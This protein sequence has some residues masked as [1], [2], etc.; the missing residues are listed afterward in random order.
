MELSEI[1]GLGK[2]R[3]ESL[4]NN[5]INS[6]MDL[7]DYH[8]YKYYDFTSIDTF[9]ASATNT[10]LVRATAIS[11]AKAVF[12]KGL[13][14]VICEFI[15]HSTDKSFKAVWYNQPFMK[16]NLHEGEE[17]FLFGKPNNKKQLVIQNYF[18]AS[19]ED[20]HIL[21]CYKAIDGVASA[22]IKKSIAQILDD[23]F[24]NDILSDGVVKNYDIMSLAEAYKEL[25]FPS[26]LDRLEEAKFRISLDKL[27]LFVALE[28]VIKTSRD[29]KD[30]SYKTIT[31]SDFQQLLPYRLTDGQEEAIEAVYQDMDRPIVMNRLV[32]GDV[33]SGKTMVAFASIYKAII[34][35]FQA[36]ML[37][38]TE[39]L[40]SQ[41][42][43]SAKT[44]FHGV[45]IAFLHSSISMT[46]K[47]RIK[48]DIE[49][50]YVQIVIA[51]HAILSDDVKF[52]NLSIVIT[53]E[54]HR[55]GVE[56]RANLSKKQ[57]V[58]QIVMSA[59][60]IPRSLALVL[61]GGLEV[62]EI[63]D[64]PGGESKIKTNILSSKKILDMWN[65]IARELKEK[66]KKCFVIVPRVFGGE[67]EIK[68]IDLIE[69]EIKQLKLFNDDEIKC[70]HGKMDSK[71]SE[72]VLQE[73]RDD[74]SKVLIA[75]TIV[76]VGID[77]KNAN[78]MVIYNAERFGLST[79][80]QLRGRVGRD[81]SEGY[82]FCVSD[83]VNEISMKRLK[84]FKENNN[85]LKIA[86]EDL[87]LRGSGTLYGTKQH[88]VS[89]IFSEVG[90]T[91][92]GFGK[93]KEIW[94]L[95]DEQKQKTLKKEAIDK[96]R[97]L[98]EKIII[99]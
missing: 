86:E 85:G 48:A 36:V 18:V 5:G 4:N 8:P 77:I 62:S 96:Y 80:H 98:Y 57:V 53:D 93:A 39:V 45:N 75:T 72:R 58:D 51:T 81:G 73:F 3:I 14:Y 84:I 43:E 79:L 25:H 82:C 33:G 23:E 12:F 70:V 26:T 91:V 31:N 92:G 95:L 13:S 59:T 32:L 67:N 24:I 49:T 16:N 63:N 9:N 2:K 90:F 27:L 38:P 46:E 41:H 6:C 50:G 40:A 89:E 65:F 71:E 22:T 61:Y 35:G 47:K 55:F 97:D 99:N 87:K 17:Y 1:N 74:N 29:K 34:S 28:N 78:I 19:K 37:C 52:K 54:Q 7:L 20:G 44:L 56:Q 60:P 94:M 76:E 88:G 68:S 11:E 83:E 15:E 42:F 30:F 21:P 69:K 10:L 66:N 64:R